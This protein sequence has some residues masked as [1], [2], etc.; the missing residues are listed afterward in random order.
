MGKILQLLLHLLTYL[1]HHLINRPLSLQLHS[2]AQSYPQIFGGPKSV[3][4]NFRPDA[5][6][7]NCLSSLFDY[8]GI[9]NRAR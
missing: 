2:N 8:N 3:S 1:Q 9:Q 5:R 7:R 6:G 4:L